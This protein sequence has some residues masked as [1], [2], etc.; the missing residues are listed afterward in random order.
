MG[1]VIVVVGMPMI[2]VIVVMRHRTDY[3]AEGMAGQL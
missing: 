1:G 3:T 2:P